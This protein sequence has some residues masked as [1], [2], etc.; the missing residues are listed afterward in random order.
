MHMKT[1]T[2][3]GV[4]ALGSHVVM[5]LRNLKATLRVIDFDRVEQKNVSAQFHGKPNVGKG[6]TQSLQQTMNYLF[7]TKLA[8]IP[9]KLTT[10][11]D[12]QLLGGSDLI[13]DCLDNGWARRIVQ[14]FA[15]QNAI[16]CLH[17][18]LAAEGSFGRVI[19]DENFVIDDASTGGATCE[20]GEHLPFICVTASLLA[21][22]AQDFFKQ[23]RKIGFQIHAQGV[24]LV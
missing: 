1:I 23:G 5:M 14:A 22:S 20:D 19:W 15:R 2:V 21:K 13:I 6:K 18:A 7:G 17:G 3:V 4:G 11:N 24:V 16:P 9:H 10:E 12:V 8:V